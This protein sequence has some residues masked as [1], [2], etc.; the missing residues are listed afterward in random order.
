ML[1][2]LSFGVAGGLNRACWGSYKDGFYEPF[3]ITKFLRSIFF[4]FVLSIFLYL[5]LDFN[6]MLPI[7]P[8]L[9]MAIVICLDTLATESFKTFLRSKEENKY[10]WPSVN[11]LKIRSNIVTNKLLLLFLIITLSSPNFWTQIFSYYCWWL[12]ISGF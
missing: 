11:K 6:K 4:G 5:F 8:A 2:Y 12:A 3:K 7:N 10:L 9:F 1:N